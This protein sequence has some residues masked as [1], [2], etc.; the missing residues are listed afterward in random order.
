MGK[1]S[2]QLAGRNVCQVHKNRPGA[3]AQRLGVGGAA[4]RG[5]RDLEELGLVP[6]GECLGP[7]Q[8]LDEPQRAV[9][10]GQAAVFYQDDLVL[11]GGWIS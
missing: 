1:L 7:E 5:H 4:P 8:R 3:H 11:G 6:G 9:T 2:W 10:P